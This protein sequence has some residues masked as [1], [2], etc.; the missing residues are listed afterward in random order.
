MQFFFFLRN[1]RDLLEGHLKAHY[2]HLIIRGKTH[3]I[4]DHGTKGHIV[5]SQ[6][7]EGFPNCHLVKNGGKG[8]K[9]AYKFMAIIP[10]I[11]DRSM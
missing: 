7:Q 5:A 8:T 6:G 9:P 4:N 2:Q 1:S 11:G 10:F 3:V